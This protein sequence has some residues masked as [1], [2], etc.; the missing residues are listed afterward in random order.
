LANQRAAKPEGFR[1][2]LPFLIT[3]VGVREV[4][5]TGTNEGA[6]GINR[7]RRPGFLIGGRL[8]TANLKA[9]PDQ[10]RPN[11]P[12]LTG[13]KVKPRVKPCGT[14]VKARAE[15][16]DLHSQGVKR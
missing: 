5:D 3:N 10:T 4:L 7:N 14:F 9:G 16:F 13:N 8:G 12:F 15:V 2:V 1:V 6:A 11:G